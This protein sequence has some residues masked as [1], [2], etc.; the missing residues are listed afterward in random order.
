[1]KANERTWF[2]FENKAETPAVADIHII[3]FIGDWYDD[4]IGRFWGEKVGVTARAFVEELAKLPEN[5]ATIRV[6]INSP[7]GDVQ[8]GINIANALREQASK[9]RTVETYVEGIAASIA[10]VIAMAG[11]KVVMA[12]NAL[13]MIHDPYG[14][15]VG[16]SREARKYA[17][18]LDTIRDQQIVN[19]YRW[20][21]SLEPAEIVALMEAETW[22]D[23][24]EAIEKGFATDKVE[25]LQA[26]AG[27]D[28]RF[29]KSLNVPDRF[30]DRMSAFLAKPEP[31]P[32]PAPAASQAAP[33]LD[34][35]RLCREANCSDIAE[36]LVADGATLE[37]VQAK[38]TSTR[39]TRDAEAARASEI[40]ALC[41]V[42]K[43]DPLASGYIAGGMPVDQV[44]AQLQTIRA[45]VDGRLGVDGAIVP[46]AGQQPKAH[47]DT[48]AIYQRRQTAGKQ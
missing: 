24:D 6:H 18:V 19:T 26:A 43:C 30:K 7:G 37:Q 11:S 39:A 48:A 17:D 12:D 28:V 34:V 45:M 21:S 41:G 4:L 14:V 36:A 13:M 27:I 16:N 32:T 46:D 23:A 2:R 10:S 38:V 25:G 22:L 42:A 47:I 3:D 8:A 9:G 35:M 15:F 29:A 44:R 40:R 5:V 20:H 1:M 33:A 31:T